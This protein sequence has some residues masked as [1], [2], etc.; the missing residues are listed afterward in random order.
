MGRGLVF[1][2]RSCETHP[3]RP[4]ADRCETCFR[5]F[6]AECLTRAGADAVSCLTCAGETS[7]VRPVSTLYVQQ[8][9][10]AALFGSAAWTAG[11]AAES[12]GLP[13]EQ[14]A[15]L[16]LLAFGVFGIGLV[17]GAR[18]ATRRNQYAGYSV[19]DWVTLLVPLVILVRLLPR[20]LD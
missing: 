6:C 16:A 3:H 9:L 14:A 11:A 5:E 7:V 19:A 15:S 17:H 10:A 2:Q 20:A 1:R 4:A 12:F 8:F 18:L 13:R